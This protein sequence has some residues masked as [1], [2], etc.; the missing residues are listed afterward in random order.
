MYVAVGSL[1]LSLKFLVPQI[2]SLSDVFISPL[3]DLLVHRHDCAFIIYLPAAIQLLC[4]RITRHR[5]SPAADLATAG[6]TIHPILLVPNS[7]ASSSL[8]RSVDA[9]LLSNKSVDLNMFILPV[10]STVT[11]FVNQVVHLNRTPMPSYRN[12]AIFSL[13]RTVI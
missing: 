12:R 6:E 11:W 5:S 8:R 13:M 7:R 10:L 9:K 4:D 2:I 3:E 1:C